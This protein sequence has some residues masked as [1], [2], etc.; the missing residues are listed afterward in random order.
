V[1]LTGAGEVVGKVGAP[2]ERQ[3]PPLAR[4]RAATG[5]LRV[6]SLA[7]IAPFSNERVIT[8]QHSRIVSSALRVTRFVQNRR[9]GARLQRGR[10][11][12]GHASA[13]GRAL[14]SPLHRGLISTQKPAGFAVYF[15]HDRCAAACSAKTSASLDAPPGRGAQRGAKQG[16]GCTTHTP[17]RAVTRPARREHVVP[18]NETRRAC[19]P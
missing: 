2:A 12:A 5:Q 6:F 4:R 3:S 7:S 13:L 17:G 8:L 16:R 10:F 1:V 14:G 15:D 18:G 11:G 9:R 19:L